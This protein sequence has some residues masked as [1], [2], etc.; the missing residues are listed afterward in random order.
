VV[1]IAVRMRAHHER[2]LWFCEPDFRC[3]FHRACSFAKF[4]RHAS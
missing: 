2:N 4:T 1:E 3:R